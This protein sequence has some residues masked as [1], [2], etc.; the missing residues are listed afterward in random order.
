M[1]TG[2]EI[3]KQ[4]LEIEE[5]ISA[6]AIYKGLITTGAY[7]NSIVVQYN[8][9]TIED[10]EAKEYYIKA[11]FFSKWVENNLSDVNLSTNTIVEQ[12][13]PASDIQNNSFAYETSHVG[14]IFKVEDNSEN[15][16][17][18]RRLINWKT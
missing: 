4:T 1:Q 11:F 8:G 2:D 9:Q 16:P 14:E 7:N 18:K 15:N 12:S 6:D 10:L 5:L 17:E 3:I 13:I